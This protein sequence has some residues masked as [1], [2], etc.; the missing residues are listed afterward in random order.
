MKKQQGFTL[1]EVMVSL[2]ILAV[3]GVVLSMGLQQVVTWQG[4]LLTEMDESNQRMKLQSLLLNDLLQLAPRAVNDGYGTQ[5]PACMTYPTGGFE[6][7]RYDA[8]VGGNGL[9]RIAYQ[10]VPQEGLVRLRWTTADRPPAQE[11]IRQVVFANVDQLLVRWQDKNTIWV[12]QWPDIAV[13]AQGL[14]E[15]PQ[16]I[17]IQL[18]YRGKEQFN[19]TFPVIEQR[20]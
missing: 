19:L 6:C 5:L 16:Q 1:I 12:N 9:I 13:T 11:P 18:S 4:K 15:L 17:S 14:N 20:Q 8:V 7:T 10:L 3:L 2:V